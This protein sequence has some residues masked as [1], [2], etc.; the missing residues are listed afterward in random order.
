MPTYAD[1]SLLWSGAFNFNIPAFIPHQ[2]NF[3]TIAGLNPGGPGFIGGLISQ[4]ANKTNG[5]GDPMPGLDVFIREAGSDQ[6][7]AYRKTDA[8]GRFAVPNLA[9]GSYEVVVDVPGVNNTNNVPV[10]NI[11][12]QNPLWA[13]LDF[14]LHSTY[15]ELLGPLAVR[16]PLE[17]VRFSA[18]PNPFGNSTKLSLVM[19]VAAKVSITVTDYLGRPVMSLQD[20][21]LGEGQHAYDFGAGQASGFYFVKLKMEGKERI[22]KLVKSN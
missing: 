18:Q 3:K 5:V 1:S 7:V 19:P 6:V 12:A 8:S 21:E 11:T 9:V 16:S 17:E 13:N 2:H 14:R 15:L 20:L 10:I 4:G 22:L